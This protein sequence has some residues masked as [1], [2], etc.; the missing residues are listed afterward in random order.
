MKIGVLADTHNL[1]RPEVESILQGC[2]CIFHAG[3]IGSSAILDRLTAIAP[4]RAVLGN[5]D[6]GILLP[7]I[8]EAQIQDI[9]ICMVHKRKD[10]PED[11]QSF[12]IAICG[13]THKYSERYLSRS[14]KAEKQTLLLNPGSCGPRRLYQA[15]TLAVITIEGSSFRTDRIE[16]H[17]SISAVYTDPGDIRKQIQIIVRETEKR[18]TT[19]E[20]AKKYQLDS[21]LTEQI[22][23]LYLTHPGVTEE[24]I[25][26][27]L[28][29]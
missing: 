4:T 2:G 27:K 22:A 18:K 24:G 11:L 8:L 13:H 21:D 10:L 14:I 7:V 3:D 6:K 19:Q 26:N 20:I 5:N 9:R 25:M 17:Q 23:R 1:L 16:I 29:L 28:G 15:I 12:D